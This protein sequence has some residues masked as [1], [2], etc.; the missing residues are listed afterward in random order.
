MPQN[1]W[2][3]IL[4]VVA[5]P[6]FSAP[7]SGGLP[8]PPFMRVPPQLAGVGLS[9]VS[10]PKFFM[11]LPLAASNLMAGNGSSWCA[12]FSPGACWPPFKVG[13]FVLYMPCF[14]G[15]PLGRGLIFGHLGILAL[16]HII[17]FLRVLL[18]RVLFWALVFLVVWA[19]CICGLQ[20]EFIF[21]WVMITCLCAHAVIGACLCLLVL[22]CGH[23]NCVFM[24]SFSSTVASIPPPPPAL[25]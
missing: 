25:L 17:S 2:R 19:R 3:G 14:V 15:L 22:G 9:I 12:S 8:W 11:C 4:R 7:F 10:A 5:S 18:G 1:P 20:I 6:G 21:E 13:R 23:W 16:Q 24:I